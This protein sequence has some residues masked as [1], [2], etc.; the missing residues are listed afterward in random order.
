MHSA[1]FMLI[2]SMANVDVAM[3]TMEMVMTVTK[4]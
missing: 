1:M 3:V 4:V 2:V